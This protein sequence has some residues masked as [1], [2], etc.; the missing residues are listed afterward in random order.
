[1]NLLKHVFAV[2]STAASER[3]QDHSRQASM[4]APR[5]LDRQELAAVA[6]GPIVKNNGV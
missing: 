5:I 6:G 3:P 2:L 1:M 4:D